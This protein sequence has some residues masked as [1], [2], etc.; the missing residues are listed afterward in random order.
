MRTALVRNLVPALLLLSAAASADARC[1][2]ESDLEALGDAVAADLACRLNVRV[3]GGPP[4]AAP[5][6]PAC[7]AG[8]PDQIA[9]TVLGPVVEPV[10]G[11]TSREFRCQRDIALSS[12]RFVEKRLAERGQGKRRAK[13]GRVMRRIAKTCDKAQVSQNGQGDPLVRVGDPCS[14]VLG[15]L[16]QPIDGSRL[17]R[18]LRA[19]LEG[20]IDDVA[21]SA[22][23]PNIVV[24]MTDDQRHDTFDVMPVVSALRDESIA[25]TNAFVTNPLC[26]PSRANFLTGRYLHNSGVISNAHFGELDDSDTLATWLEAAGYTNGLFGKYVNNSELL[27]L[28]PPQGWHEWKSFLAASGGEF[29]GPRINDNGTVRTLGSGRYSTDWLRNQAI[30]FAR[31]Q[32]KDPFF[33]FYT[34]YAPH[35]P[36]IPAHRHASE[37]A[38]HPLH[39]PPSWF[40]GTD[41]KPTWVRF[42]ESIASPDLPDAIDALRLDMLRTLIAVDEAVEKILERLEKLDLTDNTIVVFTSDHGFLWGEHGLLGKFNPYEESIRVPYA[43]R[44][45]RRYP[46][47]DSRDQM[48]LIQD[49]APTLVELAGGTAPSD[50]DGVSLVPLMDS[51]GAPWRDDFLIE[52][53]GEFIT[54]PSRSVRTATFKYIETDA[55]GGVTEE[56]YDLVADPFE[57]T[58]VAGLPA[59]AA[60]EADM[61]ARLAVLAP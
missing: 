1:T 30:K 23:A 54:A 48:V 16:G 52:T 41:G 35:G 18:C 33:V 37:L 3:S 60:V 15:G 32:S 9:E 59:Y 17:A 27:G 21:P 43:I 53:E 36:S 14:A 29:Y 56:L 44:Y 40:G 50:L 2:I 10:S 55:G 24:L 42:F 61:I 25:F 6:V 13:S 38:S 5:S 7:A 4:C 39:R 12:A 26:T 57:Q 51:N 34:P 28:T 58:N 22:L 47:G 31:R 20:Q 11:W 46:L 49:L 19:T 45:P 8:V